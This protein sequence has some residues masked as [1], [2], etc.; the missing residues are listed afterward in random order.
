MK[1]WIEPGGSSLEAEKLA[2]QL[3]ISLCRGP[4]E[5]LKKEDPAELILRFHSG[6]LSLTGDGLEMQGDLSRMLPRLKKGNLEREFLVKAS[7]IKHLPENP[8]AVDATAGMGEDSLLLAAAGYRVTLYEC[9]PVIAALLKDSLARAS[10]LP[11]LKDIV[12]RMEVR[13]EDSIR[14]MAGLEI[15]P[16]LILLD[17]MFPERRKSALI[18]KKFQLL[19]RLES[20]CADEEE[21]LGAAL[22]AVP[23]RLVIKRPLKGPYLAG[24]KPDYSIMGKAI[25]YD[26]FIGNSPL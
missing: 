6:G 17:P 3:N 4:A 11:E 24:R 14:A 22:G 7:R 12:A 23:R 16:D 18:K 21:M 2:H 8:W 9:N 25:R 19:Q 10:A 1:I 15:P 13:E 26:C 5:D 20:P